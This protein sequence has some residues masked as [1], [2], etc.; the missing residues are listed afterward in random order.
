MRNLFDSYLRRQYDDNN[1][2]Q[3]REIYAGYTGED[4]RYWRASSHQN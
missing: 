2:Q 3:R 1:N 4:K